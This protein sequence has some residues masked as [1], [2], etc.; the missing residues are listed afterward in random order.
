MSMS[1]ARRSSGG[2]THDLVQP[3][4]SEIQLDF[5]PL[6]RDRTP[7]YDNRSCRGANQKAAMRYLKYLPIVIP[8]VRRFARSPQGQAMIARG[9]AM[10][11]GPG[12]P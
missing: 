2:I 11:F 9:R 1:K 4:L 8:L 10:V 7:P 6:L 5:D 12:R 3:H